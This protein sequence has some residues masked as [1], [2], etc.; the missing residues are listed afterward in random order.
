MV[1]TAPTQLGQI[2]GS[3]IDP[4]LVTPMRTAD[5]ISEMFSAISAV[6][7]KLP[8]FWPTNSEVWFSQLEAQFATRNI[9][10]QLTKIDHVV[11][12]LS[13]PEFA[14]EVWDLILRAP[15]SNPYDMKYCIAVSEQ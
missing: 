4:T 7:L 6:S 14:I 9:R 8:Q 15:E 3:R 2:I 10:A 1:L 5:H 13:S 11:T 12:F